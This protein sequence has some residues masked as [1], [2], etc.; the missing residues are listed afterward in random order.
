MHNVYLGRQMKTIIMTHGDTDGITSGAIM[1]GLYTSGELF[2]TRPGSLASHLKH[3]IKKRPDRVT[4]TDIAINK[5]RMDDILEQLE[6]LSKFAEIIYIDHHPLP[7]N[8]STKKIPANLVVHETGPCAAELAYRTFA[9]KLSQDFSEIALIGAI[10]DYC[11]NTPFVYNTLKN[12]DKRILY[13]ESALIVQALQEINNDTTKKELTSRLTLGLRPSQMSDIVP[14]AIKASNTERS[15]MNWIKH[16]VRIEGEIAYII[17]MPIHGF[18]GKGAIY[19]AGY[20]NTKIGINASH[21]ESNMIDM[22]LRTREENIK[23]NEILEDILPELGK[24]ATGGGHPKAA[25]ASIPAKKFSK[26]VDLLNNN[27]H[28]SKN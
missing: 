1:L 20:G 18:R 8:L 14:L 12:W 15:V 27:I 24:K 4:I 28:E 17:D 9:D 23:L 25:G 26:F 16:N 2:F 21:D 13:M 3:I 22:S 6:R 19:A 5:T 7:R 10:G 11:D